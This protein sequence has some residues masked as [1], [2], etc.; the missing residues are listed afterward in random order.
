MAL[1]EPV[2]GLVI[3]HACLRRDEA[4]KGREEGRKERPCVIILAVQSVDGRTVATVAPVTHLPPERP[5][6]AVEIPV[7]TKRRLGLDEQ[8]SWIIAADLNRFVWPGPDL[9]A[10]GSGR[11][12]FGL[13]PTVLFHE[14]KEKVLALAR[15]GQVKLT[16]RTST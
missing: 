3:R 4:L 8:R 12:A 9:R 16:G 11:A 15:A 5:E 13:L 1:P 2:P 14:V 7:A 10:A 6:H